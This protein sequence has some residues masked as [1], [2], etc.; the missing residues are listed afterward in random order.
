MTSSAFILY[1][2]KTPDERQKTKNAGAQR[3]E[4]Q[5]EQALS[6]HIDKVIPH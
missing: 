2:T 3:E 1:D 6:F 4:D 5:R